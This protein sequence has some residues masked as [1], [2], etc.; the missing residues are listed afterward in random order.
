[1]EMNIGLI[2]DKLLTDKLRFETQLAE[3]KEEDPYLSEN[4][5]M[6]V[7]S[8]DNDSIDDDA[9]DRIEGVRN[10]LKVS[11]SEV[12]L[13]LEKIDRGTYGKC[14]KCGQ[15]IEAGRLDASPTAMYC[16]KHAQ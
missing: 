2:K 6:E 8:L 3:L 10:S 11:L 1:M 4:R 12:L 16:M 13:A 9:H 14:A 5:D 7:H 15:S